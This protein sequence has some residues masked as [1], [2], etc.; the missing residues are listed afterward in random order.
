MSRLTNLQERATRQRKEL[1]RT[2][3]EIRDE[4]KLMNEHPAVHECIGKYYLNRERARVI[5]IVSAEP[6]AEGGEVVTRAVIYRIR[7]TDR[8]CDKVDTVE[9]YAFGTPDISMAHL[10][11]CEEIT[12][13]QWINI[14]ANIRK[15]A[16]KWQLDV[17]ANAT[18]ERDK[19][20]AALREYLKTVK[21]K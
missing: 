1:A 17:W 19:T 6:E 21:V 15:R 11:G 5:H 10:R 12:E 13:G 4:T 14:S 7:D 16:E 18:E 9:V 3:K 20:R 2:E 8:D